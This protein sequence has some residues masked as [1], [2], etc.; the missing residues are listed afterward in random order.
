MSLAQTY[1]EATSSPFAAR[2]RLGHDIDTDVCVI[3][4]GFAGLWTA[5]ALQKRH[6]NVVLI[7]RHRVAGAASGRNGGFVSA[8]FNQGMSAIIARVG[9]EHARALYRLSRNGVQIVREETQ[10]G[11]PGINGAPGY[12]RVAVEEDAGRMQ[13]RA[14]WYARE[15]DHEIE[16]WPT[17]RV[18]DVLRTERYY[19][20]LN[21]TD[22][23]HIHPLNLAI[24]LAE[25]IERGGGRIYEDTPALDADIDGVRKTVVTPHGKIRAEHVV[26]CTNENPGTGFPD[27]SR[28]VLPVAT[29]VGVTR[30]LGEAISGAVRFAGCIQ[31]ER[32]AFNYYHLMGDRLLWGAG[33][34]TSLKRPADLERYLSDRIG[35][36]YPQLAGFGIESAW[37]GI[38]GFSIHRMPQIGM[39]RPGA[40]IASAFGGQGL[41]TTAMAGEL[42]ASAIA[43]K[44]DRWRL[45]IPFGLVWAGGWFGKTYAQINW[46]SRKLRDRID[47]VRRKK[48]AA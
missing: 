29:Y 42:I 33:I 37:A 47:D 4:G 34:S 23:F 38:M 31:D 27:L 41:N 22:A 7:E 3:G 36:V 5:R 46:W 10:L 26:F 32:S 17:E 2:P 24:A 35:A 21:E 18:R 48:K 45:F 14:D 15:L 13:R 11:F 30:P 25:A 1:Y 16:F 40:W 43:E 20:A 28:T 19:Q 8:G 6:K 12:L 44:D 39:L 9:I